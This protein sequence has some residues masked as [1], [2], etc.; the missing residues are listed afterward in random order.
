MQ[1]HGGIFRGCAH[2]FDELT[3]E[4]DGNRFDVECIG[5]TELDR[6]IFKAVGRRLLLL[7]RLGVNSPVSVSVSL[8]NVAGCKLLI[9]YPIYVGGQLSHEGHRLSPFA[10]DR[11]N[12]ILTGL[13]VENLQQFP[14][15][16]QRE[17]QLGTEYLSWRAVQPLLRPYCDTIWSAVGFPRSEYFDQDSKWIG[18]IHRDLMS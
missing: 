1:P 2:C 11:Q 13:V 16:G 17:D 6:A 7:K 8:L 14:L 18:R 12:L 15:E 4:V 9:R 5:A 10:I 3:S